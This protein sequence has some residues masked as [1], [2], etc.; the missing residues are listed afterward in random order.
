MRIKFESDVLMALPCVSLSAVAA[1]SV[2]WIPVV[3]PASTIGSQTLSLETENE[4]GA[5]EEAQLSLRTAGYE[6][7][8]RTLVIGV[9]R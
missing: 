4:G 8:P 9:T 2:F 7:A 1:S 3:N 5:A 6:N